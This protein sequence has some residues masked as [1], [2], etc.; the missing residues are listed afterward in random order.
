MLKLSPLL[1]L[2]VVASCATSTVDVDHIDPAVTVMGPELLAYVQNDTLISP[3]QRD[4]ITSAL[5]TV[6]AGLGAGDTI[7]LKAYGPQLLLIAKAY[8]AYVNADQ[9]LS[10]FQRRTRERTGLLLIR[11]VQEA[12]G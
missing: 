4:Q 6:Q 11:L 3:E 9:S 5:V 7:N 8:I 10:D 2:L 12:G 1:L